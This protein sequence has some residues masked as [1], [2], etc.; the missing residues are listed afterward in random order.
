MKAAIISM[1]SES[2]TATAEAMRRFFTSVDELDVRQLEINLSGKRSL[3]LHQGRPLAKYDCIYPKGSFRYSP[4]LRS[5]TTILQ[6]Q[7]FMPCTPSSFTI[8]HD[9]L[10]T[11]LVLQQH[12]IPMP[13]TYLAATVTA[14][15][16]VLES[17]NYP[18]IM[19]FPQG[20]QGKGVVFADSFATANS[21]LDALTA[22]RQPFLI[23][24]YIETDS[25]DIRALVVGDQ[26]VA[27]MKRKGNPADKRA[28]LHAGGEGESYVIGALARKIAVQTA[29]AIGA[30]IC[31]VDLLESVKGPVVIEANISPGL[32][33]AQITKVDVPARIAEFLYREAEQFK[34]IQKRRG[35]KDAIANVDAKQPLRLL[36]PLDFRGARVLLPEVLTRKADLV[37][38]D[39][40]EM[41]ASK[42]KVEIRRFANSEGE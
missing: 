42:D 41:L 8:A 17:A 13:A 7:T 27:A 28:N 29:R 19:K 30:G 36:E 11:Q 6:D 33:I 24:E 12:N 37:E 9:K 18:L 23:Q 22:L 31:G 32:K 15:K 2:S 10:L 25:S 5:L 20:T 14:A 26:V 4:L 21:V 35:A 3:V 16:K 39:E 38:R 40:Y 34:A 1:G